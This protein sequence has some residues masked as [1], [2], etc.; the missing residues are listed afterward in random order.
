M[1]PPK[2]K[3]GRN[4]SLGRDPLCFIDLGD[5]SDKTTGELETS[6]WQGRKHTHTRIL[7]LFRRSEAMISGE[8]EA[9][10]WQEGG[11]EGGSFLE[12]LLSLILLEP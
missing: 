8:Y 9:S 6:M 11:K 10:K 2:N 12:I 1:D 7:G 5:P 3:W 4:T